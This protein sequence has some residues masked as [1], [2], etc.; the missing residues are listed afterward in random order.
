M[1]IVVIDNQVVHYEVFGR[2]RPV[3]FLH[4]WHGSWRYW[5]PTIEVMKKH[6]RTYSLDFF[7]F[8]DSRG[9]NTCESIQ[10]YSEQVIHFLDELGVDQVA[11]VGHSMGGMVALKTAISHPERIERVA[12]V[13]A[14]IH[15][16]SLSFLLKLTDI[17]FFANTFARWH[18]L[19]RALFRFFLGETEDPAVQEILDD[20]VKSSA[21]TLRFAVSSML[22]T[23]L[24]P[25]LPNLSVPAL[26]I[27]GGRDDIVNPHQ[28][29]LFHATPTA[30]VVMMPNSRHF[31]FLDEVELFNMILLR[32]LKRVPVAPNPS[33]VVW[34][35]YPL[36]PNG[37]HTE[38]SAT[39]ER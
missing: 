24:R 2:G 13:G 1:S 28:A 17:P 6:F 3:L 26:I 8:G 34:S 16:S 29:D 19:R 10:D 22:H 18:W 4:G 7:G 37:S 30:E 21:N 39:T 14:P 38:K 36:A 31:P 27:H 15:G 23:D 35:R 33:P 5:Y 11:L 25:E 12:T 20:S 32:F 9:N